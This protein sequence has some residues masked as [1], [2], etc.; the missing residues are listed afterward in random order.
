MS[1]A[2]RTAWTFTKTSSDQ[3][4]LGKSR[5]SASRS[6]GPSSSLYWLRVW[7]A[8]PNSVS[9]RLLWCL[10]FFPRG[11]AK[12]PSLTGCTEGWQRDMC[13][14]ALEAD[15]SHVYAPR[16]VGKLKLWIHRR[17]EVLRGLIAM[18][19]IRLHPMLSFLKVRDALFHVALESTSQLGQTCKCL[20]YWCSVSF[21]CIACLE[22]GWQK[23]KLSVSIN[24]GYIVTN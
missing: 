11:K 21:H 3:T 23:K 24:E 15:F 2:C 17:K 16:L 6:W 5:C 20:T 1:S 19:T 10:G 7:G 14:T 22:M 8:L 18:A 13:V 4:S 9:A 12:P